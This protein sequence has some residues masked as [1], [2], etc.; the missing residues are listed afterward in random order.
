MKH[1]TIFQRSEAHCVT[2]L[3]CAPSLGEAMATYYVQQSQNAERLE[4]GSI[5]IGDSYIQSGKITYTHSLECIESMEKADGWNGNSWEIQEVRG[6]PWDEEFAELHVSADPAFCCPG[7]RCPGKDRARFSRGRAP[8][9][10][11]WRGWLFS[12]PT[13]STP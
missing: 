13:V 12:L 2:S 4:D 1:Y 7:S 11:S 6:Q 5:C 3:L 8:T 10:T 9:M